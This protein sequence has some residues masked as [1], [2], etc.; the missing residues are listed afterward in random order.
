M[1]LYWVPSLEASADIKRDA[2]DMFEVV[3]F[4]VGAN[5]V[6]RTPDLHL[7]FSITSGL[8]TGTVQLTADGY[9]AERI[10][11]QLSVNGT[12]AIWRSVD[13]RDWLMRPRTFLLRHGGYRAIQQGNKLRA[14]VAK[15]RRTP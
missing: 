5:A 10:R 8:W 1:R 4:D 13:L 11:V 6:L 3:L 12:H 7:P 14:L 15:T 2:E 9:A